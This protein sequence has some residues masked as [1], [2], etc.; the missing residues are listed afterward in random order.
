MIKVLPM[1]YATPF[2][3]WGFDQRQWEALALVTS[4]LERSGIEV[5]GINSLDD[6]DPTAG[7]ELLYSQGKRVILLSA[8]SRSGKVTVAFHRTLDAAIPERVCGGDL[9]NWNSI[10][11]QMLY[12]R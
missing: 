7:A 4:K 8:S 9:S 3:R 2:E 10:A 6:N 12:Y 11:S 1:K 5:I